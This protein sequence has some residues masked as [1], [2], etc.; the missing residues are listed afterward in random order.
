[1]TLELLPD[2]LLLL[3]YSYLNTFD[4]LRAFNDLNTRFHRTTDIFRKTIDFTRVRY[5]QV[6]QY[7]EILLRPSLGLYVRTLNLS[8]NRPVKEQITS[9]AK[10]VWPFSEKLPNVEHLTFLGMTSQELDIYLS[11]IIRLEILTKLTIQCSTCCSHNQIISH[12]V[13]KLTQNGKALKQLSLSC[14]SLSLTSIPDWT[15][16]VITDL[17]IQLEKTNDLIVLLY[18]FRA[19]QYLHVTIEKF[20]T[21]GSDQ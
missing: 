12:F 10:Q 21:P 18:H 11:E 13:Y 6:A 19:L 9:F 7:C 8:N 3:I 5:G 15:N 2:E 16:R 4:I 14:V 17:T 1:M 20:G